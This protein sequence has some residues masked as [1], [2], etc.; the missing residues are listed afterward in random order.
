MGDSPDWNGKLNDSPAVALTGKLMVG[1]ILALFMV[2]VFVLCLHLY[3]RYLWQRRRGGRQ[4]AAPT[5]PRRRESGATAGLDPSVL[6][7]LPVVI[8]DPKDFKDGLE[9]S[10][11]LSEVAGGE[12]ARLLPK[13]KHGFHV[14]C[15]D[16]WFHSHS[17][18]PICR[19]PVSPQSP[20]VTLEA[21]LGIPRSD[22][23]DFPTNVLIWGNHSQVNTL[24]SGSEQAP[25][26]ASSSSCSSSSSEPQN[27]A[28]VID[29]PSQIAEDEETKSPVVRRLRSLKRLLSRNTRVNQCSSAGG[30]E[31]QMDPGR[32]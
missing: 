8:F 20:D 25:T 1:A 14:D 22:N 19:Q 12:K 15:I 7:S 32:P 11:C 10:V 13:C 29:I 6:K 23:S 24:E 3:A 5:V 4:P 31:E 21:M 28:L 9:C 2:V 26:S 17:T 18:C 27:G 30:D 16:M